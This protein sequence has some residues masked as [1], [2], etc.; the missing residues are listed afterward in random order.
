MGSLLFCFNTFS[1]SEGF[2]A[3]GSVGYYSVADSIYKK[4]Y[5]SGNLMFGVFLGFDLTKN[6]ELRGEIGYLKDTGEMTLTKEEIA[7]SLL[8]VVLGARIKLM[9]MNNLSPYL[10][11]GADFYSFEEKARIGNTSD[12]AL[13]YHIEGGCYISFGQ[14]FFIDLNLRFVNADTKPFDETFKLGG[15]RI[16]LGGGYS[17]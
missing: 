11:A 8:P 4:T 5:G 17:F 15:F 2:R 3:G 16:G 12:S 9:E 1:Y 7:F 10:G 14:R 13:G 6:I